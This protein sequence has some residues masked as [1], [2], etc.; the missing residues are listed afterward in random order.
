MIYI[1]ITAAA[2]KADY[3][4][5][6]N[7]KVMKVSSEFLVIE[8]NKAVFKVL[9][10]EIELDSCKYLVDL[11]NKIEQLDKEKIKKRLSS[12]KINDTIAIY[13][14]F[15]QE[16]EYGAFTDRI[17]IKAIMFE[18]FKNNVNEEQEKLYDIYEAHKIEFIAFNR[19]LQEIFIKI[20]LENVLAV[21]TK[22]CAP[23]IEKEQKKFIITTLK[24]P[25]IAFCRDYNPEGY[26][27]YLFRYKTI[28]V[29]R[30]SN[31]GY[32]SSSYDYI[33]IELEGTKKIFRIND[34]KLNS[35]EV[36]YRTRYKINAFRD[37][38]N[39]YLLNP[40]EFKKELWK[41][42]IKYLKILLL[43]EQEI[44]PKLENIIIPEIEDK[45]KNTKKDSDSYKGLK[46]ELQKYTKVDKCD[47]NLKFD[48]LCFELGERKK[49]I[50]FL[51]LE[52]NRLINLHKAEED[53]MEYV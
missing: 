42:N 26:D 48:T 1:K 32:G 44:I 18:L 19:D 31:L 10:K 5:D 15:S 34:E 40:I 16:L 8:N 20:F 36:G 49:R 21:I 23:F 53:L 13:D 14:F 17:D 11:K 28:Q 47:K 39:E 9:E 2:K 33:N 52:I 50:E 6:D 45:I 25:N 12:R 4:N 43:N 38:L 46:K 7:K 22:K 27:I 24:E 41:N 3:L 30:K 29:F 37:V 51:K 35:F